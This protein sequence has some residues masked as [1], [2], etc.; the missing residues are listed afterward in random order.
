M[1]VGECEHKEGP[2][3]RSRGKASRSQQTVGHGPH[4]A[5]GNCLLL[6]SPGAKNGF[7]SSKS[8][9]KKA[10]RTWTR[11]YMWLA[12]PKIVTL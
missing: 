5:L 9:E 3:V 11:D 6:C 7:Y 10:R 2:Q 4:L 12:K 1:V 8:W